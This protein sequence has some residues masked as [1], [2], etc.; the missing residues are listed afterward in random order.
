MAGDT[1]KD[2]LQKLSTAINDANI[3]VT[4]NVTSGSS[5]VGTQQIIIKS[6]INK[7]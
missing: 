3:A 1:N 7:N 4:A 5:S 6:D 2:V